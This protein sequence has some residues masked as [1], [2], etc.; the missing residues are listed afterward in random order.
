MIR[1]NKSYINISIKYYQYRKYVYT[2]KDFLKFIL[3]K[4]KALKSK[5]LSKNATYDLM[6]SLCRGGRIRVNTS[7]LLRVRGVVK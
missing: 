6:L 1:E 7:D 5:S 2:F 3:K 4:T